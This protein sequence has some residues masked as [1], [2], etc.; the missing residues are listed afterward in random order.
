MTS[1]ADGGESPDSP[2][3]TCAAVPVD[4]EGKQAVWIFTEFETSESLKTL[5]DWLI[6]DHWPDWGGE[7]F[8]E[9]KPIGSL[10]LRPT[11]GSAQQTHSNYLEVVEIGGHRLETE[12]RCEIKSSE[13]WAAVAFDLDRSIG[14][15]L[16]VDRGYLMVADAG[17]R[18]HVKALK[19]VGFTNTLLN[20]VA[21]QVCPEW[22]VWVQ[23]ATQ[24]GA[25]QAAG[26][27]TDPKPRSVGDSDPRVSW[28]REGASAFAGGVAE[29]WINTASDMMDFYAPFTVDVGERFWS[30]KYDRVDAASDASRLFQ[31]LA[32]DWS[33][34]WQQGMEYIANWAEVTVRPTAGADPGRSA[35]ITEHTTLMVKARSDKARVSISDLQRVGR[36]AATIPSSEITITP[37]VIDEAGRAYVTIQ[38]DTTNVP[39]GL[40]EGVLVAG[41]GGKQAPA[42]FYVSHAQLAD[43]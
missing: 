24:V 28:S 9:M 3:V 31:R 2:E 4:V 34:A 30:G 8:K 11:R 23:R 32:R 42:L 1:S 40:Y 7:M 43:Q 22:S 19:V 14:D 35:R 6:P 17:G 13:K 5:R 10:D 37:P 12:L 16:Q 39:C 38:T 20:T 33:V 25:V 41:T 15:M 26:G 29:Q 18:R 21:T 36:V 27:S